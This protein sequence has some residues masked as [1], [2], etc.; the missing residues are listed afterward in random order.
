[1]DSLCRKILTF[2][3]LCICTAAAAVV[4][5]A[6]AQQAERGE[7]IILHSEDPAV[8]DFNVS[9]A[10]RDR[11]FN[12][13]A[14]SDWAGLG[15]SSGD[16]SYA[17]NNFGPCEAPL[18]GFCVWR[19]AATRGG[20]TF[21]FFEILLYVGA[22]PSQWRKILEVAPSAANVRG[23]GWVA[24]NNFSLFGGR[25]EWG[26]HDGSLGFLH[27]GTAY[28]AEEGCLNQS[29]ARNGFSPVALPVLAASDCPDTWGGG[30][31]RG[32]RATPRRAFERR[33]QQLGSAFTFDYWRVPDSLKRA[34]SFLGSRRTTYGATSDH[35][36]EIIARYGSVIPGG[37]GEPDLEGYPLGLVW[38]F[39][40]F[41][42]REPGLE[43]IVFWRATVINRSEDVWRTGVDYDSLYLG[44]QIGTGGSGAGAGSASPTTTCP[45]SRQASTTRVG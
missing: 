21:Q 4:P 41:N 20:G 16:F 8:P 32:D 3:V 9:A 40:A 45:R 7:D 25:V 15:L 1:M 11:G 22:P 44:F 43:G 26:P 34:D 17:L 6:A 30:V 35:Y 27:S 39:D 36:A 38:R 33:F 42:F 18:S 12:L 23:N 2:V 13:F 31:W 28:V 29:G 5:R 14:F 24:L 37:T 10:W 19:I